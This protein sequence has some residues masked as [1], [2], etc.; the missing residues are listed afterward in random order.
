[1]HSAD[2][3]PPLP[4]YPVTTSS[5]AG[6]PGR[7]TDDRRPTPSATRVGYKPNP[8]L[9]P[10]ACAVSTTLCPAT[11]ERDGHQARLLPPAV[12]RAT[13]YSACG[14][15]RKHSGRANPSHSPSGP[16]TCFREPPAK[17]ARRKRGGHRYASFMNRLPRHSSFVSSVSAPPSPETRS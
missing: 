3:V 6:D 4:R 10:R 16:L 7:L 9:M 5:E 14:S 17:G 11:K 13:S 2:R 15:Q 8:C 1:M 12:V